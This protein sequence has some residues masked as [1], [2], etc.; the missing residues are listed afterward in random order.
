M[1][2]VAFILKIAP[3]PS[4]CVH[5]EDDDLGASLAGASTMKR[6]KRDVSRG[7][8]S[9]TSQALA[10]NGDL[11][12]ARQVIVKLFTRVPVP[13]KLAVWGYFNE[14]D[15][16]LT[17]RNEVLAQRIVQQVRDV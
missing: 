17:V 6:F 1:A 10:F 15:E 12:F 13:I 3:R 7:A 16:H 11:R 8:E 4:F 14:I 5:A 9:W 2:F